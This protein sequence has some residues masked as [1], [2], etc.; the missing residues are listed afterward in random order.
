MAAAAVAVLAVAYLVAHLESS[1]FQ[2]WG[3][4]PLQEPTRTMGTLFPSAKEMHA[5]IQRSR[6]R[7]RRLADLARKY[8]DTSNSIPD[9]WIVLNQDMVIEAVNH[10]AT[11]LLGLTQ[12]DVGSVITTLVRHPEV[13]RLLS[14]DDDLNIVEI[15]SPGADETQ[16]ELRLIRIDSGQNMLIARDVTELNRLLSMRQDFVANVS[17]ELRSPL[18]VL[19]GYIES[20]SADSLDLETLMDI[21]RRLDAPAQRL[22]SLVDDLLLLTRLE[23]S[24][25]PEEEDLAVID[26]ANLITG[27]VGEAETLKKKNH[28]IRLELQENLLVHAVGNELHSV[29]MNLVTNAIRYSPNG[30]SIH[31][32]W[33]RDANL[34]RFELSDEGVGIAAEHIPR[35]TERFYR[36]DANGLRAK[37]GTGLGLAIVKHV[38][39]RHRSQLDIES[40]PGRGSKFSFNLEILN[41]R[42]VT[43]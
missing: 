1:R 41:E 29:F 9:A 36:V 27:V 14:L 18:T 16:L 31:I 35:L 37:G 13:K 38:L 42:E 11:P 4:R 40:R 23:S 39:R 10:A 43:I 15:P 17:H 25:E 12:S 33:Y 22:K 20:A 30:G 34:A 8:R 3:R 24:P 7:N 26:G 28:T 6:D 5:T 21:V 2:T 19:I 32:R